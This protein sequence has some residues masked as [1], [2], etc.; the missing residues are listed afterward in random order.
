M[1]YKLVNKNLYRFGAGAAFVFSLTNCGGDPSGK[2]TAGG[3]TT[4]TQEQKDYGEKIKKA[5]F[6]L[7]G[8][9]NAL[10]SV[11][12]GTEWYDELKDTTAGGFLDQDTAGV[13]NDSIGSNTLTAWLRDYDCPVSSGLKA[14]ATAA[15]KNALKKRAGKELAQ[16]N[17]AL[18][19][20][21]DK[22]LVDVPAGS[23]NVDI[24]TL[25]GK[26][27]AVLLVAL[28]F[29]T[30]VTKVVA[31]DVKKID[32]ALKNLEEFKTTKKVKSIVGIDASNKKKFGEGDIDVDTSTLYADAKKV[33]DEVKANLLLL[34]D[35]TKSLVEDGGKPEEK[36]DGEGEKKDPKK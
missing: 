31:G 34:A 23:K 10:G 7:V 19:K 30:K 12:Y 14:V 25:Y 2:G 20:F 1:K 26:N 5:A 17:S 28:D 13:A 15:D 27:I 4:P 32:E 18:C 3:A 6:D 9:V 24:K 29:S 36:K 21:F 33:L 16:D 35:P 11:S 22:L 8:A